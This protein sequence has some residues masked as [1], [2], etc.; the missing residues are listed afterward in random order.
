MRARARVDRRRENAVVCVR[1][2]V[3]RRVVDEDRTRRRHRVR[4][5]PQA[6]LL[7]RR[8]ALDDRWRHPARRRRHERVAAPTRRRAAGR[9]D[10]ELLRRRRAARLLHRAQVGLRVRIRYGAHC[11]GGGA[12]ARLPEGAIMRRTAVRGGLWRGQ[13]GL[14]CSGQPLHDLAHVTLVVEHQVDQLV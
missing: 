3:D 7:R 13:C 9:R 11:G 6:R 2:L 8:R 4:D 14:L 10:A 5:L 1:E 12:D